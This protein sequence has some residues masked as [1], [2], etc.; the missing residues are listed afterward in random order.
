TEVSLQRP[1]ISIYSPAKSLPTSKHNQ[2]IKFTYTDMDKDAA[3]TTVPFID[4]Q[5]VVSRPPVP[6]S[7]LGIYHKGRNGFGG[8]LAPKLITYDFTSHITVPQTN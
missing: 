8:F 1:D 7:G 2:Y 6:L 4:I 3:Q 5:E